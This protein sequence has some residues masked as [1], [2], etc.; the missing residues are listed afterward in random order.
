MLQQQART[1]AVLAALGV[2]L[3]GARD[4]QPQSVPVMSVWDKD[5]SDHVEH[6]VQDQKSQVEVKAVSAEVVK[7]IEVNQPPQRSIPQSS[8]PKVELNPSVKLKTEGQLAEK[9]TRLPFAQVIATNESV[10]VEQVIRFSLEARVIGEWVVLVSVQALN[11]P[12]RHALW[13]NISQSLIF[14]QDSQEVCRFDWPL[15]EGARWQTNVGAQAALMG[16]LT[17]FGSERRI[18]LMGELPDS[19]IPD[20]LERLP[21]LDELLREPLKKRSLWRLL[22]GNIR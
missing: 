4:E 9:P 22:I 18:G 2:P 21:S 7:N 17:R 8:L 11:H 16:F 13:K 3:W 20:R 10:H 5:E 15:A 1:R 12:D 14:R 6:L 19:I